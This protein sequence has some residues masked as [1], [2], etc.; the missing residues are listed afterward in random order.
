MATAVLDTWTKNL[1]FVV[2][3]LE[4]LKCNGIMGKRHN[5]IALALELC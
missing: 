5:P 2:Q 1:L 4:I 3:N